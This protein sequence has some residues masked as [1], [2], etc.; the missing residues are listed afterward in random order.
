MVRIHFAPNFPPASTALMMPRCVALLGRRKA[1]NRC[2]RLH[3]C[4]FG[5]V[6]LRS[7]QVC[8]SQHGSTTSLPESG[9]NPTKPSPP[10]S[11]VPRPVPINPP[12]DPTSD[13]SRLDMQVLFGMVCFVLFWLLWY[14]PS[15]ECRNQVTQTFTRLTAVS[16]SYLWPMQFCKLYH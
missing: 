9:L 6:L 12:T 10:P 11:T 1:S 13:L 7:L 15:S 3:C 14:A 5:L 8:A 4:L 2:Y 16:L